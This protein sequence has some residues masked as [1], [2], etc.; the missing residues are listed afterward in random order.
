[1]SHT[2]QQLLSHIR[3]SSCYVTYGYTQQLLLRNT[4]ICTL[5]H[6]NDTTV[7]SS[8]EDTVTL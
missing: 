3:H 8:Q 1:M 5:L 4:N 6:N 2:V 7:A